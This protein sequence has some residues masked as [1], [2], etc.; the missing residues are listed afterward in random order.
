MDPDLSP[1]AQSTPAHPTGD[2]LTAHLLAML[3]GWSAYGYELA[4]RLNEAGFGTYNKGT[5]YRTLRNMESLGLVS[6]MWD[7]SASGPARRVYS[8][9]RAGTLFLSNWLSM[10]DLHRTVLERFLQGW[11]GEASGAG[12]PTGRSTARRGPLEKD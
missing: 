4:Q 9:T 2:M 1:S 5:V 10:L 6:S 11:S 12:T 3:Q 7:T 8:L